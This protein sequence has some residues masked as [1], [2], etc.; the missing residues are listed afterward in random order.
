M[1]IKLKIS[2]LVCNIFAKTKMAFLS[3]F[4]Q[5]KFKTQKSIHP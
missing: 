3:E 1:N 2:T 4:R 5:L